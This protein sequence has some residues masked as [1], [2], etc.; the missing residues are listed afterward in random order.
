MA[1]KYDLTP[2]PYEKLMSWAF[3]YFV[4]N[5]EF[6]SISSTI[7]ARRAGFPDCIDT[8][9]MFTELFDELRRRRIIPPL[10]Q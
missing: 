3:G 1:R 8:D 4:L 6:D 10:A 9:D 5:S 2:V 7:K